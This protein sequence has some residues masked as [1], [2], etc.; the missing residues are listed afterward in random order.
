MVDPVSFTAGGQGA[1]QG[2]LGHGLVETAGYIMD[3]DTSL[4]V[5]DQLAKESRQPDLAVFQRKII[6]RAA[7]IAGKRGRFQGDGGLALISDL[8]A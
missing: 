7:E 8:F 5:G 6:T 3:G 2:H 4:P 1:G